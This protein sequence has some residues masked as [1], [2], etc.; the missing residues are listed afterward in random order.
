MLFIVIY[1]YNLEESTN[2]SGENKRN[3]NEK[4]MKV[5]WK[6]LM[7][8]GDYN[9]FTGMQQ[10]TGDQYAFFTRGRAAHVP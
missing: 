6:S 9:R 7:E 10:I 4:S 8:N 2:D 1:S 5:T 3:E